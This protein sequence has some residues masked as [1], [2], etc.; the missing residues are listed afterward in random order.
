MNILGLSCF[1]HD[2]A[3]ALIS[4]GKPVAAAQEERFSRLKNDAAF[5]FRAIQFCL[6]YSRLQLSD[7]DA[8]V[9]YEKPLRK[10]DRQMDVFL[11]NSPWRPLS[12]VDSFLQTTQKSIF[13]RHELTK[14]L[15]KIDP[16][17]CE[18]RLLFSEHHL[19]HAA[20]AFFPSPFETAVVLTMDGLGEW[21]TTTVSLGEKNSLSVLKEIHFPN[22]LGLFYSALTTFCGFKVN[23]GEYKLMGLAPY[24]QARFSELILENLITLNRDGTFELHLDCFDFVSLKK[25]FTQKMS[26][27]FGCKPRKP[28]SSMDQVYMDIAASA[29]DVLN[30]AVLNLTR[31][32]AES[33]PSK[34]LCL[35]GGVALNCVSNS[36]ILKQGFFENVWIQPASGDAGAA[37]GAALVAHSLHFQQPRYLKPQ[38]QPDSMSYAYLGTEYTDED[39]QKELQAFELEFEFLSEEALIQ[40]TTESLAFGLSV[41]WFQ[42]RMEFGPRS[43]GARSILADPRPP[44]MQKKLNLQIKFRE[45]FRPFA[46]V[47][48]EEKYAD[49]FSGLCKKSPY[50]LFVDTLTETHRGRVPAVTHLD[51]SARV[52]TLREDQN[53]KLYQLIRSFEKETGIPMLVNTSFNVRGEPIVESPKDAMSCFLKTNLDCL[54]IGN[55]F[56]EKKKNQNQVKTPSALENLD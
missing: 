42:G 39:I 55:F 17:F 28:E 32:L 36:H 56:V 35:A 40:K 29:Q 20:S 53:P 48:L 45:S 27:L 13:M 9:F 37:L 4:S 49:W 10:F 52:Q 21:A 50:M 54:A 22:S 46:P 38:N 47:L 6:K 19:S 14:E 44:D 51:A 15:K 8:V 2:S 31:H 25:M 12:F 26:S 16:A 41:G 34:N 1:Y 5:P 18:N 3:A 23:S 43:L 7:L 33:S 11:K 30:K 24:G